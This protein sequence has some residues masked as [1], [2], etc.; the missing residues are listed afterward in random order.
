MRL[1]R[2]QF[3]QTSTAAA[4]AAFGLPAIAA[5]RRA[6]TQVLDPDRQL[7]RWSFWQNRDWDWYK[8]NIPFWESPNAQMDE[9]FYYRAEVLT[10]HLRYASPQTG[11]L[12]TE[13]SC[14]ETLPWAGR[15]NGIA[16]STDLQMQ[17]IRWLKTRQYGND[18]AHYW[19]LTDGAQPRAY[20]YPAAWATWQLGM[21]HGDQAVATSLLDKFVANYEGW[22]RGLVDY[23]HDNGFDTKRQLFWQTGRD[24]GGEFNLASCQL[25]EKLRGI[26]GYKIRGG[27]G[28][29]P[30]INAVLFAEA[31]TIS[32]IARM[33]HRP[34]I[35][36]RFA[37]KAA[38]LRQNTQQHLWDPQREFFLHRWRYDEYSEG[39]TAGHKSIREW[40][41]IWETNSDRHGGVGYQPSIAGTGHGRELTG[42]VPWRFGLPEDR[43]EF[44]AAW[45]FLT[46]PDHF[47]APFGPTTAEQHDP[48]FHVIYHAC[49][50]NGQSWPFHTSRILSAA[51]N[52]LN[53]YQHHGDFTREKYFDLLSIY[54]KV[55]HE[56]GKPH[57]AEA[58][59]PFNADWVQNEWPGLDYFHSSYIDLIVTGLAG[60]R[61][62]DDNTLIVNP[63]APSDWEYFTLDQVGYRNHLISIV[64][65]RS[66]E[67]YKLGKGLTV[68]V[69]GVVAAS[70]PT[71]KRLTV[72]LEPAQPAP[73]AYEVIVS[74][75]CEGAA[76]PK[77]SASFT[78][79]Y[80]TPE[81]ALNGLYWYDP[82]Y[83]DKW[84]SR[85]SWT[86]TDWFEV[87]FGAPRNISAVRLF[88]YADAVGVDAPESYVVEYEREGAWQPVQVVS[89]QP[90]KPTAH[91]ANT[92]RFAPLLT[93]KIRVIFTH[94]P[95]IGVGLSQLQ[96]IATPG[97]EP[98]HLS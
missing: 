5:D 89:I 48:W 94:K 59:N 14:A 82:D 10:K 49:R 50:H 84:T 66:G 23:P 88:L 67:R 11:Y 53:D 26:P 54:T 9:I 90:R 13:F 95:G 85:G 8:A 43:E 41:L 1:S 4:V 76:F 63:L 57:L 56:T 19:M 29:R 27:A 93:A 55:Q 64:G 46:S 35:E 97:P 74:A 6:H 51:A 33:A 45:K 44:A 77:A 31:A 92:V 15:Y 38:S 65:D 30:D 73:Q 98:A 61:P 39:D 68:L 20:G 60:L 52:L 17:E 12:F 21:V 25:S 79:K 75:N 28:Y 22:E 86:D 71:M 18:Y 7:A 72:S 96:A 87:D 80:N 83:G 81:A 36:S 70:S 2:R 62:A 40:S 91:R 16:S 24:M 78:A 47:Y 58:H 34:E 42:Y 3:C 69:D 32:K 37:Q